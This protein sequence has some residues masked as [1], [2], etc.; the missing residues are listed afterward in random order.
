MN[1]RARSVVISEL[2]QSPTWGKILDSFYFRRLSH[3]LN[4]EGLAVKI[5]TA[6]AT[7]KSLVVVKIRKHR[8]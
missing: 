5:Q 8:S 1:I 3:S 6:S 4:Y 7:P 2:K